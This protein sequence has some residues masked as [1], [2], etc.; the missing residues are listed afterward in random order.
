MNDVSDEKEK[1]YKQNFIM[2]ENIKKI[3][4]GEKKVMFSIKNFLFS[5][6]IFKEIFFFGLKKMDQFGNLC[7]NS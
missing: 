5:C 4:Y 7:E 6:N 3:F 1:P 2:Q